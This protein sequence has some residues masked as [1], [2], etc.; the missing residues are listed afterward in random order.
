MTVKMWITTLC[1]I[2]FL[3]IGV[4]FVTNSLISK[5][6]FS[7]VSMPQITSAL[8]QKYEYG[9][10]STVDVEAQN[11]ANRLQGITDK[12][13]AYAVIEELTNYQRFFPDD[14]GYYFTYTLEGVRINVPINKSLNGKDCAD[15]KDSHGILFVRQFIEQAK[16]GGGFV[17]YNFEKPGSGIQPKLSY[18]RLIPGTDVLI[19]TGVYIDSVQNEEDRISGLVEESN[20]GYAAYQLWIVLA[21]LLIM[22]GVAWYV[23]RG[24]CMPVAATDRYGHVHCGREFGQRGVHRRAQPTRNTLLAYG[25]GRHGRQPALPH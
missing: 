17:E 11:L 7:D 15:L 3:G 21:V 23:T 2:F 9:V 5:R 22:G 20:A 13:E 10:K 25:S 18:V 16:A 24:I 4:L 8:R 6:I 19:G 12:K 14:E 1:I